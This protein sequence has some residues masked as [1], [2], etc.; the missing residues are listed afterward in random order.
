VRP[1]LENVVRGKNVPAARLEA[2]ARHYELFGGVSPVNAQMRALLVALVGELNAR[3][4]HLAVYWGNRNWHPLLSDTVRQM[5][6]DGVRRAV[7]FVTSAFGSYPSCRQYLEDIER[8]R[9]EAGTAA[10]E[11]DKLRLFYNHPGFIEAMSDRARAAF[12]QIPPERRAAAR[13]LFSA[14]SIPL[15]MARSSPYEGQLRE[16]C[17]LVAER[18]GGAPW[19]LAYQSRS[20]PPSQ[21]WL[22]P[23]IRG[24][25][26]ALAADRVRDAVLVPIGLFCESLEIVYDLDIEA[27]EVAAELGLNLVRAGVACGHPRIV[28]MIRQLTLERLDD[29]AERPALGGAGPWP[30]RCADNCCRAG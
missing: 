2:V 14:H 28:E 7:A 24:A 3:G 6:E 20:G 29:G 30:D 16:A 22:E 9:Q 21:A 8:A 27:A 19:Q 10:P 26:G 4:P 18:L 12:D 17:Q 23:E 25:I 15:V 1:F 5:A 13:L 11:I